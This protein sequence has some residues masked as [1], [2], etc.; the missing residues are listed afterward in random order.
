MEIPGDVLAASTGDD[1]PLTNTA[2]KTPPPRVCSSRSSAST[3]S[4]T[5]AAADNI[6]ARHLAGF[7]DMHISI[8]GVLEP[9]FA[10][11]NVTYTNWGHTHHLHGRRRCRRARVLRHFSRATVPQ[12]S[13]TYINYMLFKAN[14]AERH[15]WAESIRR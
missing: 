12:I 1:M 14:E 10:D 13:T 5:I 3:P 6:E 15:G 2:S 9:G 8:N 11:A 7:D 4:V